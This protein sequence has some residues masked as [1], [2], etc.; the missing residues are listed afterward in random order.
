M[1]PFG[2]KNKSQFIA[3]TYNQTT[4]VPK[5]ALLYCDGIILRII[6]KIILGI[7]LRIILGIGFY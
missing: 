6:L 4:I 2:W 5:S 1:K 7:I 3:F